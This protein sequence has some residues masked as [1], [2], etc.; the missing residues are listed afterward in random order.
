MTKEERRTQFSNIMLNVMSKEHVDK[1]YEELD[2]LG[3]FDAPASTKYH[4]AYEGGLFEHSLKVTNNL[5]AITRRMGLEWALDRSPYIIGMLHDLC[6]CDQYVKA[7]DGSYVYNKNL[8]LNGH[9]DKSVIIAQKFFSLTEEEVLC[10]RWH[11]G[12]FDAKENWDSYGK[13]VDKYPTV[14]WTHTADMM[15][16][17]DIFS[18]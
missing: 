6:K 16:A 2:E 1:L 11:M 15:A 9:G 8:V 18:Y 5:I 12:A 10:I 14:L 4:E 17:H 7:D 13:A 3:F